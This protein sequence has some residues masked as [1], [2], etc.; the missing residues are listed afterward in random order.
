VDVEDDGSF[1]FTAVEVTMAPVANN[2]EIW[3]TCENL[4]NSE[5]LPYQVWD[6]NPN[7]DGII[8]RN[9]PAGGGGGGG[10]GEGG[11]G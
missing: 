4:A 3:S 2:V 1:Q 6:A 7:Q 9:L 8:L 11:G 10:Q 5:T